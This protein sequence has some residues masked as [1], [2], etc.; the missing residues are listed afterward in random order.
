VALPLCAEP[1]INGDNTVY[2]M[3][4]AWWLGAVGRLKPGWD[5]Q[6][7]SAQLAAISPGIM[8][9]T[10]PPEFNSDQRNKYAAFRLGAVPA[11]SIPICATPTIVRSGCCW[12]FPLWYC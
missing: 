5:L 3:A 10:M 4:R 6:R 7:A 9:S 1:L 2:N 8:Q 11:A 12:E